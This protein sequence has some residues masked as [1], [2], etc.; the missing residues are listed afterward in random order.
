M[1]QNSS[2]SKPHSFSDVANSEERVGSQ[3]KCQ[4]TE[5]IQAWLVSR[6]SE[7]LGV[8]PSE[9]DVRQPFTR[10]GLDSVEATSLS[11]ELEDWLERRLSATLAWDYPTIEALARHLAVEPEDSGLSPKVDA[12]RATQRE[13]IAIIGIGCRFP[14]ARD[15]EFFWRLLRDEVN[16][17]SEVPAERWDIREFYDPD[18]AKPGK[19][20]TRWGGFLEQV[21]QF[22]Y[23]FFGIAPRE[24]ARM[25]PQQRLLLEVAWEALEDA[26]QV[27]TRL[28]STRV[29]VFIGISTDDYGR[30][31]DDPA[32][33][34]AYVATGSAWSIAANRISYLYDF[35]GPSM[36]VD[37]ACSSSLVAVHLAC[38]S[39]WNGECIL[40]LA[41]GVNLIL[42]PTVT[43][44]LAKAGLLAS[45]GCCKAFDARANGYVRGEG[46]GVV[47][48]K[49]LSRALADGD[50]IYCVIRGSSVNQDGRTNGL[51]A[52]SQQAQEAVLREACWRAGVSP[53]QIQYV[54]AHGTGTLLG[55]SIEASALGTALAI[56]RP[57]GRRCIIGSVKTNIGHLEAAASMASLIK[58]ALMLKHRMIPPSL[59]FREP[60]PHIPFDK[61]PLKV[62]QTLEPW[63]EELCPALAGV[64]SFGFG[65]TNGHVVLEEAPRIPG[66]PQH[67]KGPTSGLAQLLPLSAR[68]P[69]ALRAL[70][71]AYQD[72]SAVEHAWP[73]AVEE[74]GTGV[75]LQD[76]CYTAGARRSDHDY[77]LAVVAHSA[78]ELAEGLE[79][80]LQGEVFPGM[81]SGRRPPSRRSKLVF[82]FSGQ[83]PQWAG[84][85]QQLLEQEPVFRTTLEQCDKLL[86]QYTSWSLIEETMANESR[87]RLD[88]TEV[89]QP[90]IFAF[91]VALAAL[92]RSWGIVPD[93]VVG[94]SVGEVAAAHVAGV[95]TLQDAVRVAFHRGR[96]MQRATGQ[97][98]MAAVELSLEEAERV[99]AT[100]E[101][102]LSIA[103]INSPTSTVLSGEPAALEEVLQ[104]LRQREIFCRW[105]SVNYAF[106]SPQME[107]FQS[108]MAQVL[109]G[110]QP[111][112][113]SLPIF[114]T[115]TG[116]VSNGR[117]FD[118]AYWGRSIRQ[119]VR[120]A[121]AVDGLVEEG[122]DVF[123]E[124][125]PHPVLSGA[126]SQILRHR[127]R[128]GVVLSSLRR[129]KE[130]RAVLLG[131]LGTLYI[132]GQPVD[133]SGLYPSGGRYV[134]LPSY[135]WQ[136]ERLWIE[137][138]ETDKG[139]VRRRFSAEGAGN[140]AS[141]HPLLG[142]YWQSSVHSGTHFW[143]TDLDSLPY[144]DDHRVQGVAV[145]PAAVYVEMA[146]AA[147]EEAFGAGSHVL[148]D[149]AFK[150]VLVLPE[151]GTRTVQL[152][153]SPATPGTVSFQF[154]SIQTGDAQQQP[155]WTLHANGTIRL[156]H[157]DSA[158]SPLERVSPEEVQARCREVISG[159]EHY[160]AME[161][162]GLQY[163]PSFQGV[164]QIWRQDGEAIGRLR[165]PE[166][167][168]SGA[169]AYKIHPA[170][171][172]ACFQ[173]LAATSST[174]DCRVAEG[175]TYLP[176]GLGS[177]RVYDR[178]GTGLWS[179]AL[180]RRGEEENAATI[181]GD[182]FLLDESGQVVLEARDLRAQRL[183]R[184]T[185]RATQQDLS[186]WFYE[187]Q[188]EPKAR[189]QQ[190]QTSDPL[191]P[192]HGGSWLIFADSDGLGQTLG[193]LLE[194]RGETCVIVSPG[195]TYRISEPGHHQLNPAHPE[196]FLQLLKDTF[197]SD[198]PA[199]RGVVHLWGLEAA[200]PN[201]TTLASL[202]AAQ[203]LGCGS[204]LHL[205]Q[206]LAQAGWRDSPC[207]W[208]VTRGAQA[209]GT[210]VES[211]S[212]AQSPLWGLGRTVS[213]EH[214]E[215]HCTMVDLSTAGAPQEA[216]TL[217]QEL[218]SDH[219]GPDSPTEDQIALRGEARY[220]ARLAR[221]SP[222]AMQATPQA[223]ALDE[224]KLV[225]SGD[226]PFHL[227][228][229]TPGILDNLILRATTR[230]EPGPGEV[231]IKVY[232]TGLNFLDVLSAMGLRPDLPDGAIQ[233][234]IECAG[235]ITA[236]GEGVCDLQ[237]GDEVLA[238]APSSFSAFVTT[239][240]SFVVPKPP[241][242]SFEEAATIPVAFLTAYYA[243]CHMGR[244]CKGERVLIHAAAGGVGIAAV[245][246]AQWVGA[247]IFATAGNPEKREFLQS[248]GVN[249]IM[250]SRSLAF[251]E[252]VM[253]R[254]GGKGVDVVLNSLAGEAIPKGL[255]ILA[256]YG[257][258]LEIG[259]RDIYQNGQLGLWPFQKNLSYF[260]IDLARMAGERPAFVGSLL[261]E[262]MQHLEDGALRPLPL[263]I[264]PI[265]E[266]VDAF[267]Y[268]AQAKQIGK[269]VVTLQDQEVLVA[270]SAEVPAIFRPD[271]TYLI[272][273][274]LGGLGLTVAQW[275]V[276]QGVRHLALMGRSRASAAAQES[277]EVM[278][279]A[280]ARVVVIKADVA[281][282]EQVANV[283][284]E[285]DQTMP[286]LRGIIHAAGILDDGILLQLDRE[287]F[288]TVMAPKIDGAWNLH[289]LTLDAP[290]E[291]F[292]LFSSAASLLG[293]PGQGNYAAANAFLDALAH[294]R[295]VQGRPALSID[296]GPWAEVGLAARPDR[297]GRL[298]LRGI[299]SITPKHGLELLERLFRQGSAQVGVIPV[300]S[301]EWRQFQ[302]AAARLPL[303][304][305][306]VGEG[307]HVLPSAR[308]GSPI[309]DAIVA[310]EP[311]KRQR[312]LQSYLGEQVA[313]A[314]GLSASKLDVHES[315]TNMGID[316]LMAVELKNRM[317][318]D[319]GVD[320]PV[321]RFFQGPT[322]V[323]LAT[324]LFDQLA[325]T[326]A[327]PPA[328]VTTQSQDAQKA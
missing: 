102:S 276:E 50:P 132:L 7:R 188:W 281:E 19:M 290:L 269:V 31:Q 69:E 65:G 66:A 48:L 180:L 117:D 173:V 166:T 5:A 72:F 145:L 209:V 47:V 312:L 42:S 57:P 203:R 107:P 147:A 251:A 92:W 79:A 128:E 314:L 2:D 160:Q 296:W 170:L 324:L 237:V 121:A 260:A 200:P 159:A 155:L 193:S 259:K 315:L 53:G 247:E 267:R 217:F 142:Q 317:E 328:T 306:L 190:D 249:H 86:R 135:P 168:E 233:L 158:A 201:E 310:A 263:R 115:V 280:G 127:G 80:F 83:G 186:E 33:S 197:G 161:E 255:S 239:A 56:D 244:L 90:A 150:R 133:W 227:E 194:A 15:P 326:E 151:D 277:L 32:L 129:G 254:T 207:L 96:L 189:P 272:T 299:G 283:V 262:V 270:P 49:P 311:E 39:I 23:H 1:P 274:G 235:K 103:A 275:M 202:E 51:T 184:D 17:I 114:S 286:P 152:V 13:P 123:L 45:D 59:H 144:L 134:R 76:V 125:S 298:A 100:Y 54:E 113:A 41:G 179:H 250:D 97:G 178:P 196:D 149:M 293:S 116:R 278:K 206:A 40:T 111:R 119:P 304:A 322:V 198:R 74:T 221:Y 268:M 156:G 279:N 98:K 62:A 64:S 21:D 167:V 222:E 16:A 9:I 246:L 177:L 187:I 3:K 52:P 245:Q 174:K 18:P 137:D 71:R 295:Q 231:E 327:T 252:E 301:Q 248:L 63:P 284:A 288:K 95:L 232:A 22:D 130:E 77:R 257:R 148:E 313:G 287:R 210:E 118:V 140:G 243:L 292:V 169:D 153:V 216:Q 12:E 240:A 70:A 6:L 172:D 104:S 67:D 309:R 258:F 195:E 224:K 171:L 183:D 215:L 37:T 101:N 139:R 253:E 316:S 73:E 213:H 191:P 29:G 303:L 44:N 220:V 261:R 26:G 264:F 24:A 165:L 238:M 4:T 99:L 138:Q 27:L 225:A 291:F 199:C 8:N 305:R 36:A 163:G 214:P 300:N 323:Q 34:N 120:F 58:V 46:A 81:S 85:G 285:I 131:A 20:N 176:V 325:E 302:T 319:L 141:G 28:A 106:H 105:L 271:G 84:M 266:A 204:V 10:Y 43:V 30:L 318:L 55:D 157:A 234:G 93:A 273:G 308:N 219:A 94:H 154:S 110:F 230:Q 91:Q 175:E 236:I 205:V 297:G 218:W 143:E 87:S 108:E 88:D 242:L 208:L 265:A 136:R 146:L 14:G 82:V 212:I 162:R 294:H 25:D 282:E 11:G 60:N 78:E 35:R 181:E 68:S 211:L 38:Q 164:E 223:P 182:L 109:R 320:V 89:A 61:L 289:A 256:P 229:S 112:P 75:T 122:H 321:V 185:Q 226:L 192:D 126:I 241:R 228:I 307:D 124:L